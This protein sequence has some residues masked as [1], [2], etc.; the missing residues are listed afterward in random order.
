MKN[1]KTNRTF[2]IAAIFVTIIG[3]VFGVLIYRVQ[4]NYLA[5]KGIKAPN[6]IS[7]I[8]NRTT[9]D[10]I[11]RLGELSE[12]QLMQKIVDAINERLTTSEVYDSI[13]N[14]Q[15]NSLS[16]EVF[17]QYITAL[18]KTTKQSELVFLPMTASE[19]KEI[20]GSIERIAPELA[21]TTDLASFYWMKPIGS[22]NIGSKLPILLAKN[23]DGFTYLSGHWVRASLD[24]Y[25][26][27]KLY[28]T[29]IANKDVD[30]LSSIETSGSDDAS[31]RRNKAEK[32][33]AYYNNAIVGGL[34]NYEILSWRMDLIIYRQ[35]L[36]PTAQQSGSASSNYIRSYRFLNDDLGSQ[37]SDT[38]LVYV[39]ATAENNY[40]VRDLIPQDFSESDFS[41][42]IGDG[43]TLKPGDFVNSAE[44]QSIFGE[45]LSMQETKTSVPAIGAIYTVLYNDA[46]VVLKTV[47]LSA[48]GS[49]TAV[50]DNLTLLSPEYSISKH[51]LHPGDKIEAILAAYPFV[52]LLSYNVV[53]QN[54]RY[55][56]NYVIREKEIKA[57]VIG[58]LSE[59]QVELGVL[60]N[61]DLYNT[62]EG[63]PTPAP[64]LT[65]TPTPTPTPMPTS[66]PT[67]IPSPSPM[68]ET[69]ATT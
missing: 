19:K 67:P 17:D 56:T 61:R 36:L 55:Y 44:L 66:T 18:R 26:Y 11:T 9:P 2:Q 43:Q 60:F 68:P 65:P 64:T 28:F 53:D 20:Q 41:L 33:V 30:T 12:N 1:R 4:R 69:S 47:N 63:I 5:T 39:L 27:S 48:D 31:L 50:L 49:F 59:S 32:V 40:Q 51:A 34:E 22:F 10:E 25:N 54:G 57:I 14:F 15:L 62:T 24:V 21:V 8:L 16:F 29:A 46:H 58:L 42:N 7:L 13:P 52:D 37:P 23:D 38:R 3:L 45:V 35:K 6:I